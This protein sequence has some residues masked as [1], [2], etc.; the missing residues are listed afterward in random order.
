VLAG[1]PFRASPAA[2]LVRS[3]LAGALIDRLALVA[4]VNGPLLGVDPFDRHAGPL[5]VGPLVRVVGL[6][7]ER[8]V[9]VGDLVSAP[10]VLN[11]GG[12]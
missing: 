5:S 3:P 4:A 1:G 7:A 2:L 9:E 10:V 11:L 8:M 6:G 12:G